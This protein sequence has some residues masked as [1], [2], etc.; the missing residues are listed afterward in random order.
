MTRVNLTTETTEIFSGTLKKIHVGIHPETISASDG[1]FIDTTKTNITVI[2]I[3]NAPSVTNIGV[4]TVYSQGENSTFYKE[5]QVTDI[6]DGIQSSGNFTFNLTFFSGTKFFNINQFGVMN[7]TMNGS[8]VGVYNLSVCVTDLGIENIHQNISFCGQTGLNKTTCKNFSLTVTDQNRNP[9]ITSYYPTTLNYTISGIAS[10]Y[11]NI[12][13]YDPDGTAPDAYWYVDSVLKEYDSG[14]SV[15]EFTH[16]FGCGVSGSH[17]VSVQITDGLVNDSIEWDVAVTKVECPV[18][19]P[20][21]GGGGGGGFVG[22]VPKWGC[23]LW[24]ICQGTQTSLEAGILS[25]DDYRLMLDLCL[26]GGI[27]SESCGIQIRNCFDVNF[28]NL[29]INKPTEIQECYF[30]EDPGCFDGVKNCHDGNCELLVDCGGPCKECPT[31]SDKI[32]NQNE[33]GVDCGG[34]CPWKCPAEKP[35]LKNK[36]YLIIY[37]IIF[38]VLIILILSKT[39][40]IFKLRDTLN[41]MNLKYIKNE[42]K[43]KR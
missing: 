1:T 12:S 9:T 24:G 13:K 42:N 2:E 38:I 8:L 19:P 25:G 27:Q 18:T 30:T 6:E 39:M 17:N 23:G 28:C 14:S 3:N 11:F 16:T 34:P 36:I 22:C 41:K 35:I 4:Q 10:N 20:S 21:S 26:K 37:L 40:R 15:D 29:T 32:Q 33:N 31:C 43:N 7:V 5:V